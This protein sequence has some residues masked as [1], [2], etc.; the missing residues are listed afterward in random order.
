PVSAYRDGEVVEYKVPVGRETFHRGGTFCVCLPVIIGGLDLWPNPD[1]SL[2]V[3]GYQSC[4]AS[5]TELGSV[6]ETYLRSCD[7]K[8]HE[9]VETGWTAWL[10]I[11][12]VSGTK[13][14]LSQENAPPRTAFAP[15]GQ[16]ATRFAP[17]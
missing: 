12:Q 14:I 7:P 16:K 13:T 1:F 6:K 10:A 5:R 8:N 4:S 9:A 17:K 2:V 11:V 15:P 3:L